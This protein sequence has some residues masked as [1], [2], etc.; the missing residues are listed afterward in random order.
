MHVQTGVSVSDNQSLAV[1][2]NRKW[3]SP[4]GDVE[5]VIFINARAI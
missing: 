2:M 3:N 4:L 1:A 5:K